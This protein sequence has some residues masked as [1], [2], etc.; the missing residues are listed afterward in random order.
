MQMLCDAETVEE[1][2]DGRGGGRACSYGRQLY[3]VIILFREAHENST[4]E[5]GRIIESIKGIM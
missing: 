2:V 3:S 5:K 1:R 4:A